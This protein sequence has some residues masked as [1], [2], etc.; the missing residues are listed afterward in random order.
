M[1]SQFEYCPNCKVERPVSVSIAIKN[2]PGM[3]GDESEMLMIRYHCKSCLT[4]IRQT[5][6][7][8]EKIQRSHYAV[9]IFRPSSIRE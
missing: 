5:P 1:Y 3:E 4:F 6:L 2:M 8:N 7:H 9:Q